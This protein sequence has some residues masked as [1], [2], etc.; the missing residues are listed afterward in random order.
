[1]D[2]NNN[3]IFRITASCLMLALLTLMVVTNMADAES[4]PT[5]HSVVPVPDHLLT[6]QGEWLENNQALIGFATSTEFE[7]SQYGTIDTITG[8]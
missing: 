8:D 7:G 6:F 2:K 5:E 1:M 3:T 4:L